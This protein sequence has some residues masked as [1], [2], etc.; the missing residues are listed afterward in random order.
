VGIAAGHAREE[1]AHGGLITS[2]QFAEGIVIF[3]QQDAGN[4]LGVGEG[5]ELFGL[6]AV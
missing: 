2:H 5:H 1:G 4:E 6:A 3:A